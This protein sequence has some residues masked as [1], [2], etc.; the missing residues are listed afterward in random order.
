MKEF[1]RLNGKI[2]VIDENRS[3]MSFKQLLG[4]LV[5][6]GGRDCFNKF[7]GKVWMLTMEGTWKEVCKNIPDLSYNEYLKLSLE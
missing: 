2:G 1:I 7:Q 4:F 6:N 3:P 5:C